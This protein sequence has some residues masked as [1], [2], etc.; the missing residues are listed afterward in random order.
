MR[1]IVS[2]GRDFADFELVERELRRLNLRKPISVVIHGWIGPAAPVVEHWA[3]EHGIPI[4]RYPP[5]WEL[6]GKR[7]EVY[8][9]E[10]MLGDSRPDLIVA[11]PGGRHTAGFVQRAL[12]KGVAVL[13][14]PGPLLEDNHRP[15]PPFKRTISAMDD[16]PVKARIGPGETPTCERR[17][18]EV[19]AV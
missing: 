7:A 14:V 5:N 6:H 10:F 11:F 15:K 13:T 2:G 1:L 19:A 12:N 4:V 16:T 18:I 8:R 3:R 17:L 9:D